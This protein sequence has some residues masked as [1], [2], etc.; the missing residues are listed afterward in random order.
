MV[1]DGQTPHRSG[2]ARGLDRVDDRPITG[3][4]LDDDSG[5]EVERHRRLADGAYGMVPSGALSRIAQSLDDTVTVRVA[6]VAK[7]RVRSGMD[8]PI[9]P[10]AP[11][12]QVSSVGVRRDGQGLCARG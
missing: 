9:K 12:G 8:E 10:F 1:G 2:F 3:L 4:A 7:P 5:A 6:L 11:V